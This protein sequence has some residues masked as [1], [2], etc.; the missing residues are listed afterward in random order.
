MTY[1]LSQPPAKLTITLGPADGPA[2]TSD[3]RAGQPLSTNHLALAI[4]DVG[5][6]DRGLEEARMRKRQKR[7]NPE[8]AS[9]TPRAGSVAPGTPGSVA[10]EP[11]SKPP[12]KKESKKVAAARLAEASSTA[13]ANQTLQHLMGVGRKKKG[14][15]YAW[16]T[17]GSSGPSTPS[18]GITQPDAPGTPSAAPAP[19]APEQTNL[20]A[21]GRYRLGSW[22]ED[23]GGAR[24]IQ[25][26]DWVAA[27]EFDGTDI[28]AIQGA[29]LRLDP[30]VK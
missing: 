14:K 29:Y 12:T 8:A 15:Q 17:A 16:M 4:R 23:V 6:G 18:R 21:D 5:K 20:T 19:K 7:L 28:K 1:T 11:E 26:R 10:P 30:M 2:D 3:A 25:L 9:S 22:R 27:L 13:T 24:G